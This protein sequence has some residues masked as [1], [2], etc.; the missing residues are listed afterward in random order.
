MRVHTD[1]RPYL[2]GFCDYAS[3]D[4]FRLKRHLRVHTGEKP[5][6][7]PYCSSS[8]AQSNSLK[9]HLNLY[10]ADQIAQNK[11]M[12]EED[13]DTSTSQVEDNTSEKAFSKV[14]SGEKKVRN[15][16]RKRP[17]RNASTVSL[18]PKSQ[19]F[20]DSEDSEKHDSSEDED[21]NNNNIKATKG[22]GPS[23][24]SK[25]MRIATS[26]EDPKSRRLSV[27]IFDKKSQKDGNTE[28][29]IENE[30]WFT[31][32]ECSMRFLTKELLEEHYVKHTGMIL[33]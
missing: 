18:E 20:I 10:H 2:C 30:I 28:E 24:R 12:N 31:C 5:Y 14:D 26:P 22:Y 11:T 7:C 21:Q 1:E 27:Y 9:V 23:K 33:L 16:P 32:N 15:S 29:N 4:T 13:A 3:R 25:R 8:F 19:E 6:Q 17:K